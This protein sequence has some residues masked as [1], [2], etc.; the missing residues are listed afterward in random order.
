MNDP[1]APPII[2]KL[3]KEPY[4]HVA[5]VVRVRSRTEAFDLRDLELQPIREIFYS[6]LEAARQALIA[7]GESATSA[8]NIIKQI[9]AHYLEQ[10]E[11]TRSIRHDRYSIYSLAEKGSQDIKTLVEL[12]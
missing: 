3:V 1:V 5:I 6:S 12:E 7:I 9:E 8:A 11:A 10:L 4:P 2:A